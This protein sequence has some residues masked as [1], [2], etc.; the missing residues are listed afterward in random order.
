MERLLV[1]P[2]PLNPEIVAPY[3]GTE[4]R[5]EFAHDFE[6]RNLWLTNRIWM[7]RPR[8]RLPKQSPVMNW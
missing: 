2:A 5:V 3:T 1:T 8:T 4:A 6:R 7:R